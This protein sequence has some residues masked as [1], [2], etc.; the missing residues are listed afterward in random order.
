M[1][2]GC[3]GSVQIGNSDVNAKSFVGFIPLF[4]DIT[5]TT[6]KSTAFVTIPVNAVLLNVSDKRSQLL[7]GVEEIK[8][9]VFGFRLSTTVPLEIVVSV[10]RDSVGRERQMKVLEEAMK[11]VVARL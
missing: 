10:R 5:A 8:I 6:F 1:G 3:S 11:I 2:S 4:F 7:I 9:N